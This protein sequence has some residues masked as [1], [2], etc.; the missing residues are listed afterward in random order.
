MDIEI[1]LWAFLASRSRQPV[2]ADFLPVL[3]YLN[4]GFTLTSKELRT[5]FP[6]V[7]N[8][9]LRYGSDDLGPLRERLLRIVE[10]GDQIIYPGH[11]FYPRE[12]FEIEF[13]P[14]FL[15][16]RGSPIWLGLPALS[17]VGSREPSRLS[18][19]WMDEHLSQFCRKQKS[20]IVS[21]GARGVDQKAHAI[22][23]RAGL[24][25]LAFLPSGLDAVYPQ[26]FN[27]YIGPILSGGGAILSEYENSCEMKKYY[28]AQ[29]NRM[30]A[31]LG[32][33]TLVVEARRRSGTYLTARQTVEQSKPLWVM[34]GHPQDSGFLGSLDLLSEGATLIRDAL[35][36]NMLFA[37]ESHDFSSFNQDTRDP[38]GTGQSNHH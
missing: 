26:N 27:D 33:A 14:L 35:D 2:L 29:R 21:G 24:P 37:S 8:A 18:L 30:I 36:M 31:G 23:L 5:L 11:T 19:E 34:P 38:I 4:Q 22:A 13:P 7:E 28:F 25:T 20:F 6:G 32:R 1:W 16:L 15:V 9:I 3:P 10:K 17:V 12:F